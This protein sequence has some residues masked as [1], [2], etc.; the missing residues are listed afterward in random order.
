MKEAVGIDGHRKH[1]TVMLP[2]YSRCEDVE[3]V[4]LSLNKMQSM[5]VSM[6]MNFWLPWNA[7]STLFS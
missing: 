4:H 3:W 5:S 2:K 6:V 1:H 7:A